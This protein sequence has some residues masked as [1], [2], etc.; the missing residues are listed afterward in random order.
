MDDLFGDMKITR[1][2]NGIK[3]IRNR[4]IWLKLVENS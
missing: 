2:T 3:N 4:E 1:A